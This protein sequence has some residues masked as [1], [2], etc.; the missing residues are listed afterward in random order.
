MS[1]AHES[2]GQEGVFDRRMVFCESLL[3]RLTTD[4]LYKLCDDCDQYLCICCPDD[5]LD[6]ACH[7]Y[8][9]VFV[10]G[11]CS[12]NGR[13]GAKSGIGGIFGEKSGFQ[14]STPVDE[15]IDSS[16]VRTNQ[17]AELLAA[18]TGVKRLSAFLLHN[19]PDL[20]RRTHRR[21]RVDMVVATD[22]E[23]VCQGVAELLPKWKV[24]SDC[25]HE[26]CLLI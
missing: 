26:I 19:K 18:I 8:P 5:G 22:S 15:R 11:A 1:Q 24:R 10:D 14:W 25:S 7:H 23:Y 4:K 17:R 6:Y 9:V 13:Y 21:D 20:A 2:E 16:S 12:N 3:S